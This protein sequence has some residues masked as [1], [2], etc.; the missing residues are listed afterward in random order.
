MVYALE[1]FPKL[2]HGKFGYLL[3]S[4]TILKAESIAL[5]ESLS[6]ATSNGWHNVLFERD[7][8][9]LVEIP[10]SPIVHANESL[11]ILTL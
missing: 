5:L 9:T 1:I 3:S 4:L 8:K 11:V 10:T 7:C 6:V 2:L